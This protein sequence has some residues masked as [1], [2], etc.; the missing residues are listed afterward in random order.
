MNAHDGSPYHLTHYCKHLRDNV[1]KKWRRHIGIF[2]GMR[3]KLKHRQN[4]T[5]YSTEL[6]RR[7]LVA[8]AI[9]KTYLQ[10][11]GLY[12][13]FLVLDMVSYVLMLKSRKIIFGWRHVTCP[14]C[15]VS[16]RFG[17]NA[18]TNFMNDT[19]LNTRQI[20]SLIMLGDGFKMD[21]NNWPSI[22]FKILVLSA[23]SS[24]L[25]LE[26]ITSWIGKPTRVLVMVFRIMRCHVIMP[27]RCV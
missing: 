20:E 4:S 12:M 1:D 25:V 27:L 7:D 22:L 13:L 11:S 17:T 19:S 26:V 24:L 18:W 8:R 23:V 2:S 21:R 6:E 5:L 9:L 10:S 3:P 14:H 15:F 16:I